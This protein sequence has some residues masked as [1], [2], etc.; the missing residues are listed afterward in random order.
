MYTSAEISFYK[1]CQRVEKLSH[2][3]LEIVNLPLFIGTFYPLLLVHFILFYWYILPLIIGT[4]YPFLLGHF[5]PFIGTFSP[6]YWDIL[7][8]I[9]G[10][11]YPFLL[12]HFYPFY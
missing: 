5:T 4:F 10:T 11:F 8:L 1:N 3:H 7:P 12:G 6:F 2:L 9:I